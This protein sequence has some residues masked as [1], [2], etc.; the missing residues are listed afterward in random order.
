MAMITPDAASYDPASADAAAGS[1]SEPNYK[2][3][4]T[5]YAKETKYEAGSDGITWSDG[6]TEG[7]LAYADIRRVRVYRAPGMPMGGAS[8]FARYVL[9]PRRGRAIV[10]GNLSFVSMGKIEDRSAA[11]YTFATALTERIAK[12]HQGVEFIQ[13]MPRALFLFW[14]ILL[15]LIPIIALLSVIALI[16]ML[17]QGQSPP[18]MF[19]VTGVLLAFSLRTVPFAKTVWRNRPHRI[20][21][22]TAILFL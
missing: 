19:G 17:A 1:K 18:V 14:L 5:I 10:L 16:A 12:G 20:D 13:G 11:F 4:A 9:W 22:S 2:V 7:H 21:P 3:R 6:R 15:P 8:N